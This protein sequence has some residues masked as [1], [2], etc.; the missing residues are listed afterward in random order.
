MRRALLVGVDDYDFL[1][2]A[3]GCAEAAHA[4]ADVLGIRPVT[5][6]D[7][8]ETIVLPADSQGGVTGNALEDALQ[9]AL[10]DC[11][12]FWFYFAGHAE[13]RG[14]DLWMLASDHDPF[15]RY[16]TGQSLGELMH[17][18]RDTLPGAPATFIL[19]C[20]GSGVIQSMSVP[21][22]HIVMTIADAAPAVSGWESGRRDLSFSA[23]L[24]MG[25]EGA[26]KDPL[27]RV[28][29]LSL[30]SYASGILND[31]ARHQPLLV[32]RIVGTRVL[33]QVSGLSVDDVNQLLEVFEE[34]TSEVTVTPDHEWP[35]IAQLK[36]GYTLADEVVDQG[37]T[38]VSRPWGW[39]VE[40]LDE[41]VEQG[42]ITQEQKEKQLQ[43]LYFQRLR[44]A[45]LLEIL[46]KDGKKTPLFWACLGR[47]RVRLTPLGQHYWQVAKE[48]TAAW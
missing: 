7:P 32:G 6:E 18:I 12:E 27:G 36:A 4:L 10:V 45:G 44:D 31:A 38:F 41:Y 28:T 19:D 25:L 24:R 9:K 43:Q 39:S 37:Y 3:M 33:R 47:G 23:A 48:G 34:R 29:A 46:G 16:A 11:D 20:P 17:Q 8:I 40:K 14:A 26:A 13:A 15:S 21:A 22:G 5:T 42:V 30:F 35:G 1:P 2:Q